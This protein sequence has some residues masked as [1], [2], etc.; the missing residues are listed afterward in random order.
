MIRGLSRGVAVAAIEALGIFLD[1]HI[2]NPFI[3]S[4][5]KRR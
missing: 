3:G 4:F 2:H 1:I 5:L